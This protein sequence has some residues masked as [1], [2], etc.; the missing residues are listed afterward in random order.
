MF[1][2]KTILTSSVITLL[3]SLDGTELL[4]AQVMPKGSIATM[5]MCTIGYMVKLIIAH[6][7]HQKY[8]TYHTG[9]AQIF[10]TK[11]VL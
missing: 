4:L 1:D 11:N 9:G 6:H 10:H 2:A 3:Y 7:M 5:E 8:K